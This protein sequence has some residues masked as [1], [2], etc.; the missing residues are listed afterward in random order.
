MEQI[1]KKVVILSTGGTIAGSGLPGMS[2]TYTA[3][4]ISVDEILTSIPQARNL[5]DIELESICSE[6]SN[7]IT[8]DHYAALKKRIEELDADDSVDGIVITHGTDTMEE[9]AFLMNL[10]LN[11][12]KPVIFTGAMRPATAASADGPMNLYQAIAL[13]ASDQAKDL[14]VMAVISNSIYAGRDLNKT[15]SFKTDAFRMNE[16]GMLGYMR[17]DQVI[18]LHSPCRKHTYDSEFTDLDLTKMPTVEIFYVHQQSDPK[19]LEY[20]LHNYDGVILA[21]TGGGNYSKEIQEVVENNDTDCVVVRTS[22]LLEGAAYESEVFDP[23]HK[24]IPAYRLSPHK[25]RLLLMLGLAK[26]KDPEKLKEYFQQ[27]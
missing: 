21:G 20:M 10:V 27:Y 7:D 25:A 18:L 3:G 13:A 12:H 11:T 23:E 1:K 26:T 5:A 15:N 17:D 2:N 19:L 16:F 14:G 22:R 24:T 9:S 8:F 6:D 4:Q